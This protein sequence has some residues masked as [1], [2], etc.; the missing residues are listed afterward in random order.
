MMRVALPA[1]AAFCLSLLHT[2]GVWGQELSYQSLVSP[3]LSGSQTVVG[4][5]LTYPSG[6][7]LVTAV[8]V[9]VPPGG[10]TGWHRHP[11]PLFGYILEGTLE[12]DFGPLGTRS[13]KS[14]EGLLEAMG[15]AHNGKNMG[16]VPVRI[17]AVYIGAYGIANAE[18]AK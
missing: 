11:V 15:S 10:E 4:E 2:S 13:Y 8:V 1:I 6:K 14:G 3:V 9:T 16:T 18:V 5:T 7:S 17:L 12:V